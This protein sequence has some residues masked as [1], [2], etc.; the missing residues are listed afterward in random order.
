MQMNTNFRVYGVGALGVAVAGLCAVTLL[1]T[2]L[3]AQRAGAGPTTSQ[4]QV[5][6]T[7]DIAPI[8]QRSCQN[9]HRPDSV[10]PMSLTT[11]DAARPWARSIKQ[12]VSQREMPPWFIDRRIGI[13]KFKEDPSLSDDEIALIVKWV[14]SG[15][16]QGDP[17]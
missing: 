13:Q 14:D 7:K 8:L 4:R 9:C 1:S 15:A 2:S 16:P 11:Y 3:S 10:A 12:K 6:F 5:T 17:R